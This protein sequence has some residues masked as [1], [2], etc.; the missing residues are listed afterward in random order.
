MLHETTCAQQDFKNE[1]KIEGVLKMANLAMTAVKPATTIAKCA[2]SDIPLQE[3]LADHFGVIL[4]QLL[5]ILGP[6]AYNARTM[7][8]LKKENNV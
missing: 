3:E 2:F 1:R 7:E 8:R 6:V 4:K 5:H